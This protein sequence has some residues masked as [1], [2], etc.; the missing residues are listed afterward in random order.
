[1][2]RLPRTSGKKAASAS[3]VWVDRQSTET[4]FLTV[5]GVNN[6][7]CTLLALK[8]KWPAFIE[9]EKLGNH[10]ETIE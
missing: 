4:H 2:S 10:R 7:F 1:M 6:I 3:R 9:T 8:A 5:K